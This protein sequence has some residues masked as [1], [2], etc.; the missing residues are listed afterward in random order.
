MWKT[1]DPQYLT[2]DAELPFLGV[3]IRMTKDGLLLRQHHYTLDFLREHSSHISARKRT[4]SGEPEHFRR[5]TPLPPDPTNIEHPQRVK[6]L[7]KILGGLLW[8]STRTRPDLSYSVSS[9]AQVLTKDIEGLKAKAATPFTIHQHYTNP[10]IALPNGPYPRH[11]EMA[12]FTVYSGASFA[13]AGKY[14]QSG[15][16]IHLSFGYTRH[17]IHWQS[18]REIKISES[19]AEAELYALATARNLL[20]TF[21]FSLMNPLLPPW[22]CHCDATTLLP[23]Q[24]L[25]NL[26]GELGTSPLTEKP[27]GKRCFP[28]LLL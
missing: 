10:R 12:N 15:Y 21:G 8:L 18:V 6:I 3:L 9:A 23:S 28:T 5:E 13:P 27:F 19:S 26:V 25:K 7:Q 20:A 4:T 24:C 17:L 16:T 14:S 2:M 11:R 22:S 1:S